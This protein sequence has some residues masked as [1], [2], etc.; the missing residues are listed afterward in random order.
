MAISQ[1]VQ[2]EIIRLY[3]AGLSMTQISQELCVSQSAVVYHLQKRGIARRSRSDATVQ[4]NITHAGK[5][6]AQIKQ[7]LTFEEE[8]L[9]VA[10]VML[11]WGEGTKG[12]T[13][14]KFA[15]SDPDMIV[16]FLQ[17]LRNICGIWEERLKLLV[18]LYP[19][20]DEKELIR[21]WSITTGV[22]QKNFYKSSLHIGKKGTYRHKSRYGTLTVNY[23]DK[24]LLE[25]INSWIDEYRDKR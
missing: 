2:L 14:V 17:F 21:F 7:E 6:A 18:H 22:P 19:D 24:K 15:N 25:Q 20:H 12:H 9:R 16:I 5:K 23:S 13:A 8:K 4:W 3:Q 11:Y 10:G 1:K